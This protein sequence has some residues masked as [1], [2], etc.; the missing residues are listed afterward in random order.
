VATDAAG[1]NVVSNAEA[2]HAIM[3]K[4]ENAMNGKPVPKITTGLTELDDALGGLQAGDFC[5][6]A[7]RPG[8]MKTGVTGNMAMAAA[9]A[10]SP[11]LFFELEMTREQLLTRMACVSDFLRHPDDP[12]S[13]T[14]FRK[15]DV[16]DYQFHR[17]SDALRTIPENL[18]IVDRCGM[19][20][21]E[22]AG[23]ARAYA[24]RQI[25]IGV[26]IID[27]LQLIQAGDRYR[28]NMTQEVTEISKACKILAKTIGWPVIA[29]CQL[30]RACDQREDKR[31]L[32]T[33]LRESGQLEQDADSVIML[34]RD[35]YYLALELQNKNCPAREEKEIELDSCKDL[36]EI[37]IRKNR[38]GAGNAVKA[39][40]HL[41]TSAVLDEKPMGAK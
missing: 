21:H 34:Y 38:H 17:M 14:W 1:D 18:H 41:Q 33:D 15:G 7:G 9:Q 36:L 19:T 13:Y 39:Y 5:I 12:M 25:N 35:S 16:R 20:I 40:C 23:Y 37:L 26:V 27:Y 22:I 4:L 6:V 31:P 8:M 2:S 11:V 32:L 30:S 29:I 28:G 3:V 24:K 10:G